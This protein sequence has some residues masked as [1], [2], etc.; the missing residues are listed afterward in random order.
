MLEAILTLFQVLMIVMILIYLMFLFHKNPKKLLLNPMSYCLV[1]SV[2]YLGVPYITPDYL[3]EYFGYEIDIDTIVYIKL[4][5]IYVNVTFAFILYIS[6]RF[7]MPNFNNL[8]VS[9]S[10]GEFMRRY[11]IFI[12]TLISLLSIYILV[13]YS[14]QLFANFSSRG[15]A[16][17]IYSDVFNNFK[18]PIVFAVA[19]VCSITL[20]IFI[21]FK[22]IYFTPQIILIILAGLSGDRDMIFS[23]IVFFMLIG[24]IKIPNDKIKKLVIFVCITMLLLIIFRFFQNGYFSSGTHGIRID[25]LLLSE[26]YHTAFTTTYMIQ[27]NLVSNGNLFEYIYTPILKNVSFLFGIERVSWYADIVSGHIGRGFGFAGNI[28]SESLYYGGVILL[29]A[30]PFIISFLLLLWIYIWKK[31]SYW[32]FVMLLIYIPNI[33]LFF[34]GSFWDNY[35]AIM[36]WSIILVLPIMFL[37]F[38]KKGVSYE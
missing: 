14:P 6:H 1:C 23:I 29:L 38:K 9:N 28:M 36:H 18:I 32:G 17:S 15:V 31:G 35:I 7:V 5:S 12:L 22:L 34:R 2:M 10:L 30:Y 21:R 13:K 24:V 19:S 4:L 26:F 27:N 20:S 3:F 11:L 25:Y 33:R 37:M 16:Y 8:V